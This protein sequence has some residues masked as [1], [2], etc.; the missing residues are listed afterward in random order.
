M[1]DRVCTV[2]LVRLAMGK[3]QYFYYIVSSTK[4]DFLVQDSPSGARVELN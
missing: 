4:V 2:D 1:A 3:T